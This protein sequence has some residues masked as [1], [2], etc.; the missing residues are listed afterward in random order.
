MA[1]QVSVSKLNAFMTCPWQYYLA[2]EAHIKVAQ[3]VMKVFGQA[4]HRTVQLLHNP[5]EKIRK[6]R[7]EF[8]PRGKTQL[9][10]TSE[11]A[12]R[13]IWH[14]VWGEALKEEKADSEIFRNPTK[15][16]FE[17]K[18]KKEIEEE[19]NKWRYIG[20][21]MIAKY[22]RDNYD[23]PFP[24]TPIPGE[25]GVE[26]YFQV[27]APHRDDVL[28]TGIIDQIREIDGKYWIIDL[29]TAWWDFGEPDARIQY[30]VHHSYQFT[31]YSYAFRQL[32][33][34]EEA[35]IIRYPLGYKR[36][37]PE[38][39]EKIDKKA[40]FTTRTEKDYEDLAQ[41]ID[42][43]INSLEAGYSPQ[44]TFPKFYGYACKTC[45]YFDVCSLSENYVTKPVK[46]SEINWGRVD[47]EEL[48]RQ[49]TPRAKELDFHQPRLPLRKRK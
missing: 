13:G 12:A 36:T 35:G 23:A 22:W 47:K 24:K 46:V 26:L 32:Y 33:G 42:F 30:P 41:L 39:K 5:N 4:A 44:L 48:I 38:T 31:V 6:A 40:I 3:W 49:L 7:I 37:D 45:D 25:K 34:I 18:T 15:I 11:E 8:E 2:H 43:Y 10:P 29:K 21:S 19:K 20:A 14:L 28:L 1:I 27:P 16:R 17:G 9:F